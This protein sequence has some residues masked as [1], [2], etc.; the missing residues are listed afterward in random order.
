MVH[1]TGMELQA[2]GRCP[3]LPTGVCQ[4]I[5]RS[6][7]KQQR[8]WNAV[9]MVKVSLHALHFRA[10]CRCMKHLPAFT[11]WRRT[12]NIWRMQG[13]T[14]CHRLCRQGHDI[15]KVA[16][17]FS[18]KCWCQVSSFAKEWKLSVV[19]LEIPLIILQT[20]CG[21]CDLSTTW[22]DRMVLEY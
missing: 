5:E 15:Q 17:T 12:K 16:T 14:A 7:E 11:L 6:S 19:D 21:T 20:Y 8:S 9:N 18:H 4:N 2:C 3:T 22:T 1:S 13:M 10:D